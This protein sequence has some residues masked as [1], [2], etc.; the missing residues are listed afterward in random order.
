MKF[1]FQSYNENHIFAELGSD[2]LGRHIP[3]RLVQWCTEAS[4]IF[5]EV[6]RDILE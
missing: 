6:R 5:L 1:M 2:F 3:G 4:H